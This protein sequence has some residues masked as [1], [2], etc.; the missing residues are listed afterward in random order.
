M[1]SKQFPSYKNGYSYTR[2]RNPT[3]EGVEVLINS[4]ERGAGSLAFSSGCAAISTALLTFLQTGDHLVM[5]LSKAC[6]YLCY[7]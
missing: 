5:S 2:V 6:K 4:L 3:R 7:I 1:G